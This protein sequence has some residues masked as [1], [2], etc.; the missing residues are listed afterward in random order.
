MSKISAYAALTSPASGDV[1]PVVD[2]SDTSMAASGTTKKITLANLLPGAVLSPSGDTSGVADTAAVTAAEA[3]GGTVFFGPGTFWVTGLVKQAGTIWQ[4]TGRNLTTIML[5]SGA[6]ADVVKGANFSTLTCTGSAAG[7]GG[8]A[9]RDLTIDGNKANQSGV[10]NGLRVYAYDY[11]M[12]DVTIRNCLTEGFYSEWSAQSGGPAGADSSMEA[13]IYGVKVYG[14]GA[15][16]WHDRG[17]HDSRTWDLTIYGNGSGFPG[18]WAEGVPAT[19]VA[20]GSNGVAVSTFAGAGTLNVASTLNWPTAS[21]SGTQGAIV[22]TGLTGGTGTAT[23]TYTGVTATTFTGCTTV[24]GSGTLATA[25]PAAMTGGGYSAGGMMMYGAHT[26]GASSSWGYLLD[27]AVYLVGC[28]AEVAATGMV[29]IRGNGCKISS[30]NYFI[31]AGASQT[32]CGIQLGDTANGPQL[33][34]VRT[35]VARTACTSAA[36]AALNIVNDGTGNDVE[37][38]ANAPSGSV[39]WS[40]T[41]AVGSRYAVYASGQSN[42]ANAAN[43]TL[44]QGAVHKLFIPDN[45]ASAFTIQDPVSFVDAF[46]ISTTTGTPL[47]QG[48]NGY[49]WRLYSDAYTTP[50]VRLSGALGHVGT[51]VKNGGTISVAAAAGAGTSPPA[52]TL[53]AASSD[54]Q[55]QVSIGT[56]TATAAGAVCTVTF[57]SA[58]TVAPIVVLSP[59]N[60]ATSVLQPYVATVATGTFQVAFN[61]APAISQATGT[62]L[63]N[64]VVLARPN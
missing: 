10:S 53:L 30:G 45:T 6:N 61:V 50:T 63:V 48:P 55:G 44:W 14:C 37:I 34:Q 42:T 22:V 43:S 39:V 13:R 64:Y 57:S 52:P 41:R 21:I 2:I 18:Y 26:Y 56:G 38:S 25:N 1:L 17:P 32:G 58:F 23:I 16:G 9:I 51:A 4:G 24:S 62:Y 27:T 11:S 5:A 19:T 54:T 59:A 3:L 29:L 35:S 46:G 28:S 7:I 60:A 20:A 31:A 49:E 36:T 40:G 47:V 12:T 15:A 8:W 33:C